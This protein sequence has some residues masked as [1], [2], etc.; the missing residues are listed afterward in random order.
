M[1]ND[2]GLG[3]G[4]AVEVKREPRGSQPWT[5][6]CGGAGHGGLGGSLDWPRLP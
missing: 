4:V 6:M 1:T 3:P 5:G 2:Q